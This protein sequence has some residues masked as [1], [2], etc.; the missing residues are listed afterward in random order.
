MQDVREATQYI[1]HCLGNAGT[2][3]QLAAVLAAARVLKSALNHVM[4]AVLA[5]VRAGRMASDSPEHLPLVRR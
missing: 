2:A 1:S 3:P 5:S 4:H